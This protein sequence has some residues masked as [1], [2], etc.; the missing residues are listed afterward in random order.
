M[1]NFLLVG[2]A[3]YIAP[4]HLKAIRD[5]GNNL[6]AV[7]DPH[8]SVGIL[9]SY[10]RNVSYFQE[11]ERFDRHVDK[12]IRNGTKI[13]YVSIC[14]PNYLHDA[15]I[16][17]GLR[18][19][20]NIICEKPLVIKAENCHVLE[21]KEREYNT[22]VN[23]ILQLRLHPAIIALKQKIDHEQSK[24]HN[25]KLTYFT[26]R[27]PWYL[28]SWKGDNVK[29][30][31]LAMN[32]G[33]HF[34]DMLMWIFGDCISVGVNEKSDTTIAGTMELEKANVDWQLSIDYDRLPEQCK[35]D[36]RSTYRSVV[37]DGKELEFS[38]GFADLHTKAYEEIIDDRGFGIKDCYSSIRLVNEIMEIQ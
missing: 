10:F 2:A 12:L 5:T 20:A 27:G 17:F 18:V 35:I 14:S 36:D 8:D 23:T 16:R 24:K 19:G 26:S 7:V 4:R 31:G 32:I 21:E 11:F 25:V 22:K 38:D 33:I 37:V 6:L 13:D 28:Y 30:G 15:H 3:G 29:S 34:F 1:L 9:D